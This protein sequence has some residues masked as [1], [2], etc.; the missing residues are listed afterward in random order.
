MSAFEESLSARQ[1]THPLKN[2]GTVTNSQHRAHPLILCDAEAIYGG[3]AEYEDAIIEGN[4]VLTLQGHS[5]CIVVGGDHGHVD[6]FASGHDLVLVNDEREVKNPTE[7][8]ERSFDGVVLL[9]TV[10]VPSG[11]LSIGIAY[12]PLNLP[13]TS[14]PNPG[15]RLVTPVTAIAFEVRAEEGDDGWRIELRAKQGLP[16]RIVT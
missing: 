10:E 6:V 11:A 12:N 13:N 4:S 2:L 7:L 5:A 8:A 3:W 15:E 1:G 16:S 9:G 14:A